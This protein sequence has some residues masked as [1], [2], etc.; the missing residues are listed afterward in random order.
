MKYWMLTLSCITFLPFTQL[1]ASTDSNAASAADALFREG[2]TFCN[3]ASRLSRTDTSLARQ[4]FE[5]YRSHLERAQVVDASVLENNAFVQREHKRCTLIDDNIAR[6]EAMPMVEQSLAQCADARAALDVSDLDQ[7]SASF[8]QFQALRDQA[9]SVTPT[10]LRVGS[11]AV[12]M[13]VCDRLVE[14]I[15]LAETARQMAQQTL[16]RARGHFNRALASCE[17]GEGMLNSQSPTPDTLNALQ[18]VMGRMQA[19]VDKGNGALKILAGNKVAANLKPMSV[20]LEACQQQLELA[21]IAIEQHLVQ[22]ALTA[23]SVEA[24]APDLQAESNPDS[25]LQGQEI[26]QIVDNDL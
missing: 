13:R 17:V 15:S 5:Q 20:R 19:H 23:Q 4:Q 10:V 7:A 12:R 16:G 11:V 24:G 14:K 1:M 21:A 2:V 6:A 9:L 3:Q 18:S 8:V 25:V 22:K 26:S